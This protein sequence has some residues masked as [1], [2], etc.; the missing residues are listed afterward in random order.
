MGTSSYFATKVSFCLIALRS[1]IFCSIRNVLLSCS[2]NK[3]GGTRR[4]NNKIKTQA[5]HF[6]IFNLSIPIQYWRHLTFQPL[7][8]A[9]I[10][11][12]S[13]HYN[14]VS[15]AIPNQ[16]SSYISIAL[17]SSKVSLTT[18]INFLMGL[19]PHKTS[20]IFFKYPFIS[21]FAFSSIQ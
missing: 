4:G 9:F 3:P 1:H 8:E 11:N 6:R 10:S 2:W 21:A 13:V 18:R 16:H 14:D 12:Q 15:K 19:R 7:Q 17:W 20:S 5:R